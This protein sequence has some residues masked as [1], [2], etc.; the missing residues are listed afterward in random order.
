VTDTAHAR[1]LAQRT[2]VVT[3]ASRGIGA[4]VARRLAAAGTRIALLA[5]SEDALRALAGELGPSALAVPCDVRDPRATAR[6]IEVIADA[7]AG[8]PEI[9]VNNAGSFLIAPAHEITVDAFRDTLEVNLT[10][11]FAFVRAFLPTM[12]A[13]GRGHVVTIGSI[14]DRTVFPG[15]AAYAASK[16]GLRALHEVLRAELRGS[17]IRASLVSPGPVDTE[18]W[19]AIDPDNQPGFTPRAQMLSPDDVAAAVIYLLDAPM[20]VNVDEL[21][22]SR[23]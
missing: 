6:A 7:F 16:H 20:T 11:P 2:A 19:D 13:R 10:A 22:L 14:A 9:V 12:Q 17:G 1:P 18:L 15:N 4:A 21:R 8:G 23:S 3:G 5:R